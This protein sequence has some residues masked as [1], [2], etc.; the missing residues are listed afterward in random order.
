MQITCSISGEIVDVKETKAGNPKLPKGWKWIGGQAVSSKAFHERYAL[1]T[2][3]VPIVS[4]DV[5][6]NQEVMKAAWKDLDEKL[7]DA[8]KRSTYAANWAVKQLWSGDI[9][10]TDDMKKCPAYPKDADGKSVYLYGMQSWEGW[11]QSAAS[12]L[13]TVEQSYKKRRWDIVWAGSAGVPNVRYPYPYPVP[14]QAW[15]L[16]Q[17]E[18]G[19]VVFSCRLPS[20]RTSVR[21]KT[22]DK[23][24]RYRLPALRHLIA[25][26]DLRGEAAIIRK[27]KQ[28]SVKIVGYFPKT[29]RELSGDLHV[30]TDS[31]SFLVMLN[32]E[33]ERLISRNADDIRRKLA[34]HAHALQRWREDQKLEVRNPKRLSRKRAEDMQKAT[35]KMHNRLDDFI[36]TVC[37][38]VVNYA[39]RRKLARIIYNDTERSYFRDFAW[40]R[41]ESTLRSVCER[42]GLIFEKTGSQDQAQDNV[43]TSADHRGQYEPT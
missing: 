33:E 17:R 3:T 13:R 1:R 12:V 41:L 35:Q 25:R 30:R 28:I 42:E 21:L 10:R 4:P 22:K 18:G 2:I 23:G 20:G 7:K 15:S 14:N 11:A 34:G 8:W 27:G 31:L 6:G 16:E 38:E 43:E 9:L 32:S 36:K 5:H 19:E 26:E 29:E 39:I 24:C 37:A 40:H